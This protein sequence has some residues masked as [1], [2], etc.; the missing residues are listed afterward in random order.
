MEILTVLL[1]DL[2]VV[3]PVD[4]LVV[5]PAVLP[6]VLPVVLPVDLPVDLLVAVLHFLQDLYFVMQH[7][8]LVLLNVSIV[9]MD[10]GNVLIL[11]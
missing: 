10:N 4:L 7:H 2:L 5:L 6:A 8:H 9:K 1:V 11:K 3:L